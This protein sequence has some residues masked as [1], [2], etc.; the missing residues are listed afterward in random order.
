MAELR[1]KASVVWNG[2]SRHGSGRI[3]SSSGVLQDVPYTWVARF[4]DAPG[5]NPEELIAAAHAACFSMALASRLSREGYQPQS[6]ETSAT[7]VM[8]SQEQGGFQISRMELQTHAQVPG[9]DEAT[10]R[11]IAQEAERGCPV[12]TALR[13]GVGIELEANLV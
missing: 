6:I 3:S 2:D 8:S 7:C 10:F 13:G 12:S 5:T 11:R 9:I 1:R 4:G